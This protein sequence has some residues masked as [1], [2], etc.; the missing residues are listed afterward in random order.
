MQMPRRPAAQPT[1]VVRCLTATAARKQL[2]QLIADTN[3][4]GVPVHVSSPRGNAV[5]VSEDD[6]NAIQE[7]LYLTGIPG[8]V[9]RLKAAASAPDDAFVGLSEVDL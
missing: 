4:D 6:W 3:T 2:Y 9:D 1:G 5:I 7:T 8:M